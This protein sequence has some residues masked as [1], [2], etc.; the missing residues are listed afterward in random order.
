MSMKDIY[1]EGLKAAKV[2]DARYAFI[3]LPQYFVYHFNKFLRNR[4]KKFVGN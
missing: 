1:V 4:I 3:Y 2:H